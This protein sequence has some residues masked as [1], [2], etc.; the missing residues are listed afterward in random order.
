MLAAELQQRAFHLAWLAQLRAHYY[1]CLAV[2]CTASTTWRV[3]DAKLS[4]QCA[5]WGS[6]SGPGWKRETLTVHNSSKACKAE[7]LFALQRRAVVTT[8][9][10]V[11]GSG[12]FACILKAPALSRVYSRRQHWG[13]H[14]SGHGRAA[15]HS[16]P[17]SSWRL[18]V[19]VWLRMSPH[20]RWGTVRQWLRNAHESCQWV[21]GRCVFVV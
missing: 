4:C 14:W 1:S 12:V 5:L 11:C 15:Q 13:T 8:G 9:P 19:Q 17:S 18:R 10:S 16:W 2:A 6:H 7:C 21:G 20:A 3:Q